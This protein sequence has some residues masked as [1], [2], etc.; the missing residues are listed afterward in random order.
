MTRGFTSCTPHQRLFEDKIQENEMG[1][2]S[3][4]KKINAYRVSV[5][6]PDGRKQLKKNGNTIFRRILNK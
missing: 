1:A 3:T 2:E 6:K 5:G 4:W